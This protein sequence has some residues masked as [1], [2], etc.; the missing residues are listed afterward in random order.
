MQEEVVI[1]HATTGAVATRMGTESPT[2]VPANVYPTR[3][4]GFVAL[5]GAGDQ[6]FA[7]LCEAIEAPDAPKDPR[8]A[9]SAAR[10]QNRAA[11][12]QLVGAWVAR[13]DLADVEA[14]FAAAGV[15]GT[16]VRSVD[17]IIGDAHVAGETRDLAP[18]VDV[19]PRLP[20]PRARAEVHAHAGGAPRP[21]RRVS[22]STPR[23]V[24]D[25][26]ERIAGRRRPDVK[27]DDQVGAGPL[28]GVRV[29]DLSQWLAGPA[30]AALLGDFG[31]EVI[32]IELPATGG[33]A[34]IGRTRE[35]RSRLS[36]DQPEQAQRHARR[37]LAARPR[38]IPG[39]GARRAT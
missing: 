30:A 36:G 10:L 25:D 15:A 14:R 12:D 8:F 13:H 11:A 22:A 27:R 21:A 31:A 17:E 33:A 7:R 19:R 16:A 20:R 34:P 24:R 29:L 3:D 5:S 35:P 26:V 18:H 23:T 2:V 38:G 37:A 6:P 28:A 9:T 1:R 39:A 4:G 32:M